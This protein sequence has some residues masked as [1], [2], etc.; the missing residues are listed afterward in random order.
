[1]KRGDAH[2]LIAGEVEAGWI[3]DRPF[4]RKGYAFEAMAATIT[5]G[6]K[7]VE[8]RR[9]VAV[10]SAVNEAS[11]HLMRRLG[12]TRLADGDFDLVTHGTR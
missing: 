11:Q 5:W 12:M 8:A 9:I 4:W 3:V 2:N 7:H 1:M 6:W 10:T